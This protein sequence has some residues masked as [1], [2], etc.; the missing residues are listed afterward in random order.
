MSRPSARKSPSSMATNTSRLLNAETGSIVIVFIGLS[1]HP[2]VACIPDSARLP[3]ILLLTGPHV[4]SVDSPLAGALLA[5]RKRAERLDA[6][7]DPWM[8]GRAAAHAQAVGVAAARREH[9]ARHQADPFFKAASNA[10]R[11]T[12]PAPA[13]GESI[14]FWGQRAASRQCF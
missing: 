13:G 4:G 6:L 14:L 2:S 9:I 3:L 12:S 5:R 1:L 10:T 8:P 7:F 11:R